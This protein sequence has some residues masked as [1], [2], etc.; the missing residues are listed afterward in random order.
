MNIFPTV[1]SFYRFREFKFKKK[2][3]VVPVLNYVITHIMKTFRG[4]EV[5][6]LFLISPL[7]GGELSVSHRSGKSPQYPLDRRVG[8]HSVDNKKF[9]ASVENRTTL[10]QPL[11]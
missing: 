5:A 6:P 11:S 9:L 10:V 3:K 1:Y 2:G 7:D 4:V 8:G